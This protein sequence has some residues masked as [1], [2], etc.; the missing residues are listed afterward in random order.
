MLSGAM[1]KISFSRVSL[2]LVGLMFVLPF[3][4]YHHFLPIPSF[5]GEWIAAVL[6]LVALGLFMLNRY[7]QEME[8]PMVALV[9]LGLVVIMLI[10]VPTDRIVLPE[11]NILGA[12]YLIWAVL[13]MMLSR[14][15]TREL[16]LR[17]V[18]EILSWFLLCGGVLNAGIA[19]FQYFGVSSVL[20][21]VIVK[22]ARIPFAN[23][24]QPNHFSNYITLG[25]GSL[26]YLTSRQRVHIWTALAAGGLMLYVLSFS[27]S[28]SSWLYVVAIA[29]LSLWFFLVN[30]QAESRRLVI[31]GLLLLPVFALA[32]YLAPHSLATPTD[33]LFNLAGSKSD[34]MAIWQEALHMSLEEPLL[35]VGF[36]EFTWRHFLL[37]DQAPD[38]IRG[39][40]YNHCHNI[41]LQVLA[42][43]GL[44]AA[45]L[46]VGGVMFW[47]T[48][49]FR[50]GGFTPEQWWVLVLL[51]VLAIHSMLEY[52]LWYS[53][54]LGIAAI[55]LGAGEVRSIRLNMQRVG[56]NLFVLL[57]VMGGVSLFN[58]VQS[59]SGFEGAFY[60][61]GKNLSKRS[62]LESIEKD[63]R[64]YV[65]QVILLHRESLL[66]AYAEIAISRG[67]AL[68]SEDLQ[69]K[70][71]VNGRAMHAAPINEIVYR[72][73][74]LLG[75]NGEHR[76]AARQFDLAAAAYPKDVEAVIMVLK[77]KA[78]QD[79]HGFQSLLNHAVAWRQ[80]HRPGAEIMPAVMETGD[81]VP[82]VASA[83]VKR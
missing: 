71:A 52:P 68:N 13:L 22:S 28:R 58:L 25:L 37:S 72:Q 61:F 75:L 35:G 23:I 2:W 59:Y 76:A 7:W 10:Q 67:I 27:G 62:D 55:L 11:H 45:L 26:L 42:E 57:F 53:Y 29:L 50:A 69:N 8:L 65:N 21:G 15:L 30:R 38:I 60:G 12:S 17:E 70:L 49:L 81:A 32:Q 47:L 79:A 31:A 40:L 64:D 73:A 18:V 46:L 56:R 63:A 16:G 20:D 77:R 24:G 4:S 3:L 33:N 48:R 66:S 14:V 43:L 6:G 1:R 83:M 19:I 82:A 78:A 5:Y 44:P 51:S 39:G 54:F 34:R 41:V 80:S 36:G 74:I 9:P